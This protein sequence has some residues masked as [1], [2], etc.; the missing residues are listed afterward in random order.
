LT[1][2]PRIVPTKRDPSPERRAFDI[3][4]LIA[5]KGKEMKTIRQIRDL[6]KSLWR[7]CGRSLGQEEA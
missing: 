4:R 3:G 1:G 7:F 6:G 2:N 5:M